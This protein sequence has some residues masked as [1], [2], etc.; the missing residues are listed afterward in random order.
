MPEPI[1]NSFGLTVQLQ[2][3]SQAQYE[4]YQP[5]VLKATRDNF[6]DFGSQNVG[7]SAQAVVR[8]TVVRAAILSGFLTGVTV[9]EVGKLTPPAVTWL[10]GEI[11][12]HVKAVTNPPS[13][14]N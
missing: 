9:E 4:K 1:E 6:Y 11:E 14:P 12:K 2:D 10:A 5:M 3:F 8:G 13:D 7:L